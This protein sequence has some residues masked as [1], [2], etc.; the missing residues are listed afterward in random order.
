MQYVS[1]ILAYVP[2]TY[3]V[4]RVINPKLALNRPRYVHVPIA[5]ASC[6]QTMV[7][8]HTRAIA[9]AEQTWLHIPNRLNRPEL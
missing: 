9:R 1:V 8:A 4:H 3:Y 7:G 6:E 5:T 2:C